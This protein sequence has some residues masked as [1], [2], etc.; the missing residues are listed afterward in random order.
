MWKKY[1]PFKENKAHAF[2]FCVWAV[3]EKTA[4]RIYVYTKYSLMDDAS[5]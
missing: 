5:L 3:S 1:F 2:I 4:I